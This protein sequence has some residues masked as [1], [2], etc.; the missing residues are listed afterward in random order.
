MWDLIQCYFIKLVNLLMNFLVNWWLEILIWVLELLP[1]ADFAADPIE[2][3]DFGNS[4]G[5]FIPVAKMA[6]HF[7]L[8][9]G[10]LVLYFAVQHVLRLVKMIG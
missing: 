2:W 1:D 10:A 6:S 7:V 4:V 8:I 3:G 5:Y 9:L